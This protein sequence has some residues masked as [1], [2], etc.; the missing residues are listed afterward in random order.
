MDEKAFPLEEVLRWA[1]EI[2]G[3]GVNKDRSLLIDL[4]RESLEAL[5]NEESVENLR[6]FC[7]PSCG[8]LITMPHELAEPLK[9]KICG[10]VSPVRNKAFEFLGFERNDCVG[11]RSDLQYVGEFPTLFDLPDCGARI[12][13]RS[14]DFFDLKWGDAPYLLVQGK[15]IYDRAVHTVNDGKTD[16]GERISISKPNAAPIYSKTIF[17]EIT[18]VRI[19][20]A[21]LNIQLLWC[22]VDNYGDAPSQIGLLSTYTPG[23]EYPGFK[24]YRFLQNV[25]CSCCYNIEVLGNI[26]APSLRYDNELIRGFD[27]SAIRSMLRANYYRSKNDINGA[28]FNS[29][30]AVSSIRKK[31]ERLSKDTDMLAPFV[32]TSAGKF[33]NVF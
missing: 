18:S 17:K 30:I 8:C 31:N 14:M 11:Y 20:N 29:N 4:I 12:A 7:I 3:K 23:D 21:E 25:D 19:V 26:R 6:K 27:S 2:S 33:P 16:V 13:A 5:Y 28:T 22:E 15:D 1:S 24:R 32:P 9:Y 10:E